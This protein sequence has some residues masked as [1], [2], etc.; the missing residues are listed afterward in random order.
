MK[1][2]DADGF[3]R[4]PT[5]A[6]LVAPDGNVIVPDVEQVGRPGAIKIAK[7]NAVGIELLGHVEPGRIFHGDLG[8]KASVAEIGPVAD[9]S[10]ADTHQVVEAVAGDVCEE[11]SL[12]LFGEDHRRPFFFVQDF[13]DAVRGPESLL[14]QRFVPDKIDETRAQRL[15]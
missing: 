8:P 11:H 12:L 13:G 10:I 9:L 4:A 14:G 15:R 7:T 2:R 1:S 6:G 3:F 5:V